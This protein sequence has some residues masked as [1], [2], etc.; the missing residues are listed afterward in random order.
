MKLLNRLRN[1]RKTTPAPI[2]IPDP[3]GRRPLPAS[4]W[5]AEAAKVAAKNLET[6]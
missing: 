2:F 4:A 5:G 3:Q 6:S 1:S